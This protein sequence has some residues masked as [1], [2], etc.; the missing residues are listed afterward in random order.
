MGLLGWILNLDN[1]GGIGPREDILVEL[2]T[3]AYYATGS[4]YDETLAPRDTDTPSQM[5]WADIHPVDPETAFEDTLGGRFKVALTRLE[6][7][8]YAAFGSRPAA[9][10][11]GSGGYNKCSFYDRINPRCLW[12]PE[13]WRP[14]CYSGAFGCVSSGLCNGVCV[15]YDNYGEYAAYGTSGLGYPRPS[16]PIRPRSEDPLYEFQQR[17]HDADVFPLGSVSRDRDAYPFSPEGRGWYGATQPGRNDSPAWLTTAN[18]YTYNAGQDVVITWEKPSGVTTPTVIQVLYALQPPGGTF[19]G[20]TA[21]TMTSSGSTYTAT[22]PAQDHGTACR[23]YVRYY[24]DAPLLEPDVERFDPGVLTTPSVTIQYTFTW[25]THFNPFANGLP[26]LLDDYLGVDIRH[27]TDFYQFDRSETIQ[28][29]LINFVRNVLSALCGTSCTWSDSPCDDDANGGHPGPL[30]HNPRNRS[31]TDSECC[32]D[33]PIRFYWS[34]SNYYPHYIRGG[35]GA[36]GHNDPRPYH[37]GPGVE[38]FGSSTARRSWYG[39]EYVF[40]NSPYANYEYGGDASWA[41]TPFA[42]KVQFN[43]GED[44]RVYATYTQVGL[45]R[46]MVIDPVHIE[47]LISAIDYLID[48]GLWV[49]D[50]I[51]SCKTKIGSF[52]GHPCGYASREAVGG[53]PWRNPDFDCRWDCGGAG[54]VTCPGCFIHDVAT[55]IKPCMDCCYTTSFCPVEAEEFNR[56]GY[57]INASCEPE[58]FT[59]STDTTNGIHCDEWPTPTWEECW[60]QELP[61]EAG[62]CTA[63]A[64][65]YKSCRRNGRPVD[66][67]STEE[68]VCVGCGGFPGGG[69]WCGSPAPVGCGIYACQQSCNVHNTDSSRTFGDATAYV[70]VGGFSYRYCTGPR[71]RGGWD[72]NHG[73]ALRKHRFDHVWH[74]EFLEVATGPPGAEGSGNCYGDI[75]VCGTLETGTYPTSDFQ[76]V[77][78]VTFSGAAQPWYTE[79]CWCSFTTGAGCISVGALDDP[80]ELPGL[81][82]YSASGS[83]LCS[84][85]HNV[86][87][88]LFT[89]ITTDAN[90]CQCELYDFPTCTGTAAWVAID[91]NLDNTGTPYGN[92][93]GRTTTDPAYT[94]TKIPVLR[95][96]DMTKDPATWMHDCPCETNTGAS[97]CELL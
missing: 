21:V 6:G 93:G 80:P 38:N 13:A 63:T 92:Y 62:Y 44:A 16:V 86:S 58:E 71:C 11:N 36:G 41:T 7:L 2:E 50:T 10:S 3:T 40:G 79:Q 19:G 5:T 12:G 47:E 76:E 96:Y 66:C 70:A 49:T 67:G 33:W 35:K 94:G 75:V 1:N 14:S 90:T 83:P 51:K 26:E 87:T 20:Y 42:Q 56:T 52:M 22:I 88:G 60:N 31:N 77:R 61:C 55:A 65:K 29:E 89:T 54:S 25:F 64:Y 59:F 68:H 23:W 73:S 84:K 18:G 69:S 24:Y 43:G 27:G 78:K 17:D 39:I 15:E 46:G 48:N 53:P 74:P 8:L 82:L 9:Y 34:G 30:H 57:L 32:V 95:D 45:Q 4:H 81:G 85:T 97:F 91:L 37:N 72:D 28:V